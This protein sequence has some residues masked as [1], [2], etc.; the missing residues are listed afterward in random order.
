MADE[1]PKTDA[2]PA[3]GEPKADEQFH[4]DAEGF[5]TSDVL[6]DSV[7]KDEWKNIEA[8]LSYQ[9]KNVAEMLKRACAQV[10]TKGEVVVDDSN[11][12]FLGDMLPEMATFSTWC[13]KEHIRPK[14]QSLPLDLP[15]E[16]EAAADTDKKKKGKGGGG[17]GK[18]GGGKGGGDK[19]PAKVQI[20]IDNV[21]RIMKGEAAKDKGK[22]SL[23]IGANATGWLEA[24]EPGKNLVL[25]AP[26][27]LQLAKEVGTAAAYLAPKKV[28]GEDKESTENKYKAVRNV[29]DAIVVYENQYKI[30]YQVDDVPSLL[31]LAD[32]RHVLNLLKAKVKFTVHKCLRKYPALLSSSAFKSKHA[33]KFLQPYSSQLQLFK[34]VSKPGPRLVLL[35]SPPDT[36]KTSLAPALPELFPDHKVI[37]CCLARR[38]NLEVAQTLYNMGIPFAWVHN[39]M[40]TCSWLCGLRG[41]STSTSVA[42]MEEKLRLGVDL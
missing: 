3:E 13:Y 14:L 19:I 20:K 10:R 22:S 23:Q 28:K 25:D 7:T 11:G 33:A 36:G 42:Q 18:G 38:V 1:A 24:L 2:P 15:D 9:K 27:E 39:S 34:E 17:K 30:R 41:S 5:G 32:A 21:L 4:E 40:I 6:L 16:E 31:M 8:S 37:F 12:K 35:R 29:A 26:W